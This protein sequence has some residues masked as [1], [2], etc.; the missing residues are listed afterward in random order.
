MTKVPPPHPRPAVFLSSS[1]VSAP[2][3]LLC[4]VL[5]QVHRPHPARRGQSVRPLQQHGRA[6]ADQAVSAGR[7]PNSVHERGRRSG[8]PALLQRVPL[9]PAEL[10]A[11]RVSGGHAEEEGLLRV[12]RVPAGEVKRGSFPSMLFIMFQMRAAEADE[13]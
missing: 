7:P 4:R 6:P 5:L 8:A 12:Q 1:V 10:A 11:H 9:H 13:R 3:V 2:H